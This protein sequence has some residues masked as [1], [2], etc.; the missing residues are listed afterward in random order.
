M[1]K[2]GYDMFSVLDTAMQII[3]DEHQHFTN[4]KIDNNEHIARIVRIAESVG[5][6]LKSSGRPKREIESNVLRIIRYGRQLFVEEWI[7]PLPGEVVGPEEKD[8]IEE[9][10]KYVKKHRGS[11]KHK[12]SNQAL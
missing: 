12:S 10:E 4:Q 7:Q 11:K 9:F 3:Q 1:T 2:A 8:A 5:I 6:L